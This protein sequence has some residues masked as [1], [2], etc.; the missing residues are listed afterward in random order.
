MAVGGEVV[1][2]E[3][4][5]G[6][7]LV[8][9]GCDVLFPPPH[10]AS[11]SNADKRTPRAETPGVLFIVRMP[12]AGMTE[13]YRQLARRSRRSCNRDGRDGGCPDRSRGRGARCARRGGRSRRSGRSRRPH[14]S[15]RSHRS[16]GGRSTFGV[17]AGVLWITRTSVFAAGTTELGPGMTVRVH[18]AI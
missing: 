8:S 2:G 6:T 17:I 14:R 12:F 11:S 10:P 7:G 18:V 15:H 9:E 16:H 13:R 5:G 1:A 4:L 3:V